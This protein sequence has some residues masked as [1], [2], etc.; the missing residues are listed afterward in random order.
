MVGSVMV[1]AGIPVPRNQADAKA[2]VLSRFASHFSR[3]YKKHFGVPPGR[4]VE[5]LREVI[6][7]IP[8]VETV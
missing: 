3:D 7:A 6:A 8:A 4:D 2:L 1:E 5:R